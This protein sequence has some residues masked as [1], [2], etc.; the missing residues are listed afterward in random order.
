MAVYLIKQIDGDVV[1]KG[2][3]PPVLTVFL[4]DGLLRR[5][6]QTPQP[7]PLVNVGLRDDDDL[8]SGLVLL[9]FVLLVL[10]GIASCREA[11]SPADSAFPS[12]P[13]SFGTGRER[14]RER[15]WGEREGE[16]GQFS[17]KRG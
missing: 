9:L 4:V 1:E 12:F 5:L 6:Q 3:V 11:S 8:R 7:H 15:Q 13:E 10:L 2:H 17:W 16:A 14:K